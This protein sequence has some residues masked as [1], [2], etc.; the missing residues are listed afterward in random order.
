[1][2]AMS[3]PRDDENRKV[4]RLETRRVQRRIPGLGV[5]VFRELSLSDEMRLA[6]FFD[7][8]VPD[9]RAFVNEAVAASLERPVVDA[10]DVDAWTERARAIARVAVAEVGGC[11]LVYRRLAGSGLS[12]DERL[13]RAMR[14]RHERQLERLRQTMA[15]ASENVVRLVNSTHEAVRRSGVLEYI[16]RSQRQVQ[17]IAQAYARAFQPMNRQ[18]EQLIRPSVVS[19][20]AHRIGATNSFVHGYARMAD[21][22]SRRLN[23]VVRPSYFGALERM[24]RQVNEA[25]RPHSF[26]AISRLGERIQHVVRPSYLDQIAAFG[27]RLQELTRA[28]LFETLREF[29][30]RYGAWLERNWAQVYANPDHPPPAMFVLASLPMAIGLPLLRALSDDDVGLP[31]SDGQG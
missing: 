28:P 8:E 1:M 4:V 27:R 13:Y 18:I 15:A 10:V 9:D 30:E 2:I 16:E 6:Q 17:G 21:K 5:A 20:L 25:L 19:E 31:R 29:L 26:K 23:A 12:G 24:S 3:K 7:A 22:F 11:T 14:V